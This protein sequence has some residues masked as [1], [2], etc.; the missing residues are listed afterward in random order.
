MGNW[1]KEKARD[2]KR[3]LALGA[4]MDAAIDAADRERF[5]EVYNK[6]FHCMGAKQRKSYHKRFLMRMVNK[7]GAI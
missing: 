4:E 2:A 6:T 7:E 5:E 3:A 1:E